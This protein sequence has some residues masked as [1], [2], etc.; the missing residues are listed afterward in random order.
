MLAA[1]KKR[2]VLYAL[3]IMAMMLDWVSTVIATVF[4]HE[5]R[6][7]E[8]NP[9]A[10]AMGL[11]GAVVYAIGSAAVIAFILFKW[12]IDFAR[13]ESRLV[14]LT[15]WLAFSL[16]AQGFTAYL[17]NFGFIPVVAHTTEDFRLFGQIT[18]LV[19]GAVTLLYNCGLYIGRTYPAFPNLS[20]ASIKE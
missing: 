3:P 18:F 13:R 1:L 16:I 7:D 14:L 19:G 20:R 6:F 10:G 8:V 2:E 12:G 9:I 17:N 11:Q 4:I 5:G 15:D